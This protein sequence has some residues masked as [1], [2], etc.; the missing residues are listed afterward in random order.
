MK[1]YIIVLAVLALVTA[2][3]INLYTRKLHTASAAPTAVSCPSLDGTY[4]TNLYGQQSYGTQSGV[5]FGLIGIIAIDANNS[6]SGN[7]NMV[8]PS[9]VQAAQLS[10]TAYSSSTCQGVIDIIPTDPVFHA[11]LDYVQLSNGDVE[12]AGYGNGNN[13]PVEVFSGT[14]HRY[15]PPVGI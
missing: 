9:G 5:Q 10:G 15:P 6:V 14:L 12:V 7:L 1:K 3:T 11:E 13:F 8:R 4:G 2:G